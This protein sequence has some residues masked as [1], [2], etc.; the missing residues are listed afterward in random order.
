MFMKVVEQEQPNLRLY[1][2]RMKEKFF[3][4]WDDLLYKDPKKNIDA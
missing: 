2:E 1:F 3:P 4:D